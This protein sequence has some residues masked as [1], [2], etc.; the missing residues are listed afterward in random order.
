MQTKRESQ[1]NG[2]YT[3]DS[4][5]LETAIPLAENA[6]WSLVTLGAFIFVTLVGCA[7]EPE[8]PKAT[9]PEVQVATVIQQ[10]VPNYGEWV[11]QLN[12]PVNVDITPKVQGYLLQQNYQNGFFVKKGELLFTLDPRQYEAAV[13]QAKAQVGIAEANLAKASNDVQ[14]DTPLAAQRAIAQRDLDTDLTNQEAMKSQVQAAKASLANAELNLTWTKVYSPIEGIAGVSSSQIGDLV[15]TGTKMVTISQVNPIWAYFNPSESLFLKFAPKVT[16]YITGKLGSGS[17]P[18]M[19]VEFIQSNDVPYPEKGRIIYVNRQ[20]GTG[21]G[22]IQMAAEFPN[23]GATLRP[24]GFGRIRIKIGDS[25]NALL[26]PQPAVIEVQSQYMLIVVTPDNKAVFRPVKVG[27]RV[28][29][30]WI[31]TEGLKPDE[32]VVVEGTE[33]VQ[34]FAAAAPQLAKEGIPVNAKPYVPAAEAGGSN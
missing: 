8:L 23:K 11:S 28:G 14:R 27:D 19:P 1:L 7:K 17:R 4:K 32:R 29:P 5:Q 16:A 2:L 18:P 9:P 21:T 25:E 31:I 30:N 15:G 22:T 33:R 10:N 26:V 13:E 6:L 34:M 3:A 12:G 20:V 24:G